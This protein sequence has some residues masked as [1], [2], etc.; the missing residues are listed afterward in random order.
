MDSKIPDGFW[1]AGLPHNQ[2]LFWV[3][4]LWDSGI[5]MGNGPG[6]GQYGMEGS[7]QDKR[8][9][10]QSASFL[11]IVDSSKHIYPFSIVSFSYA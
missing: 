1:P 9:V 10:Y 6:H 11:C 2:G 4:G 5:G 3:G 8:P 7:A